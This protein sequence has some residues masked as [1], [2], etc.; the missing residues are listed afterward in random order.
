MRCFLVSFPFPS[1]RPNP[2]VTP[3]TQATMKIVMINDRRNKLKVKLLFKKTY[4]MA[5]V[6]S[7]KIARCDWLLTWQDRGIMKIVNAL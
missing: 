1:R 3:A 5:Q 6:T 2:Q 4:Y 7:G